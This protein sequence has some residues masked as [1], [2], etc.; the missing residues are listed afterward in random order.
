MTCSLRQRTV[1]SP[2]GHAPVDKLG[3]AG[4]H[5]IRTEPVALHDTRAEAFDQTIGLLHQLQGGFDIGRILEIQADGA[6]A[7]AHHI[8]SASWL[9]VARTVNP[10]NICAHIRE[11]HAAERPRTDP[12]K[13]NNP[14]TVQW[15][16]CHHSLPFNYGPLGLISGTLSVERAKERGVLAS[17]FEAF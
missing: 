13:L 2:T 9:A 15:P 7:A 3:I 8:G 16:A 11:Q 14:D 10:D 17:P 12:C 4:E 6:T 1:L 5:D